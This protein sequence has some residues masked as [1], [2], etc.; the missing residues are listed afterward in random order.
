[1]SAEVRIPFELTP[2]E[3][4]NPLWLRL[5]AHFDQCLADARIDNDN[6]HDAIK[7]AQIRARIE[8]FKGLIALDR[9]P[10]DFGIR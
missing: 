7:T 4:D 5:R 2:A 9:D 3:R 8:T 6:P 10:I 1:M